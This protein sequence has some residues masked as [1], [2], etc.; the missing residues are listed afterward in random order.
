MLNKKVDFRLLNL[1][2]IFCIVF[3]MYCTKNLWGGVFHTMVEITSPFFIAFI[4][5]YALYPVL[6][7]FERNKI[8]KL[9][10][11]FLI[12][13]LLFGIVIILSILVT[14]MLF[15]QLT[16]LFSGILYFCKEIST[17]YSINLGTLQNTLSDI[18]N[19]MVIKISTYISNGAINVIVVSFDYISFFF[20][21]LASTIY[22]LWDMKNI[23]FFL[24]HYLLQKNK[25]VFFYLKKVDLEM[26]KYLGGF[27]KIIFI[28]FFEYSICF[29]LIRHPDAILLG[30]LAALG[31]FIPYFGGII[32]NIIAAITAFAIHPRLFIRTI[33]VFLIL[34]NVDGY[35]INPLVYGKSNRLHPLITIFSIFT[36]GILFG[37]PGIIFALPVSICMITTYY[38]FQSNITEKIE[39]LKG[40]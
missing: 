34:A 14:P 12:F 5:A 8:P 26:Q 40:E 3:L 1:L 22:F 24:K 16:S 4:L 23:R 7:F 9:L 37:F 11:I 18:F 25:K 2:I 38:F 29:S 32:T 21:S 13:G 6:C 36:G 35:V 15:S 17:K 33:I 31:N 30:I 19:E 20:V 27:F 10:A 28:S 39:S